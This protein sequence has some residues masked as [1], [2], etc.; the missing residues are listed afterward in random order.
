MSPCWLKIGQDNS[1]FSRDTPPYQHIIAASGL[2]T[3]FNHSSE[4]W[5]NAV[6]DRLIKLHPAPRIDPYADLFEEDMPDEDKG[7]L[8]A[9]EALDLSFDYRPEQAPLLLDQYLCS[10]DHIENPFLWSPEELIDAGI[11][12]PYRVLP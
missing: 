6:A 10:I 4:A 8:V 12:H 2:Y 9:R 1:I 5:L 7:A 3:S 11:K